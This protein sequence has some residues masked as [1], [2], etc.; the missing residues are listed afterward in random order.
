MASDLGRDSET[1]ES[2]LFSY[3]SGL[4][5]YSFTFVF[6]LEYIPDT[7][8]KRQQRMVNIS[9]DTLLEMFMFCS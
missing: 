9:S 1:V 7:A 4:C 3:S 8:K 5:S 2:P 6:K